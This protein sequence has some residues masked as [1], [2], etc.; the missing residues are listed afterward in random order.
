M[1]KIA[2][3]A[4]FLVLL[5]CIANISI[6]RPLGAFT[7]YGLHMADGTT[8][9]CGKFVSDSKNE[10]TKGPWISWLSGFIS[11]SNRLRGRWTDDKDLDGMYYWLVNY[12]Q[13]HAMDSLMNGLHT[14]DMEL[15]TGDFQVFY[16]K[17]A[18]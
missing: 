3:S 12:C 17:K 18:H 15:G 4:V 1:R 9:S 13:Q 2:K 5:S 7:I 11:G 10:Y 6:A 8:A 16:D 14:L